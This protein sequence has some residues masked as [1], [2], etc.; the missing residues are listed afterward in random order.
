M[1]KESFDILADFFATAN[2][3]NALSDATMSA[4]SVIDYLSRI[5]II[6]MINEKVGKLNIWD[7]VDQDKTRVANM[8]F[9]RDG[10]MLASN[11]RMLLKIKREY[12]SELEGKGIRKNGTIENRTPLTS[13]DAAID[14][15]L[16]RH[17]DGAKVL[18]FDFEK[19]AKIST[20][21]KAIRKMSR[22][23]IRPIISLDGGSIKFYYD[24][25]LPAIQFM[26]DMD[27]KE[28]SIVPNTGVAALI[29][30][31]ENTC[32]IMPIY[33]DTRQMSN[34]FEM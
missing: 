9:H 11:R 17:T 33:G 1:K 2:A 31:D 10:Y 19:F 34:I 3:I 8:V 22:N 4:K 6:E 29:R 13:F 14:T 16:A 32:L 25:L 23:T 21:C 24:E 12:S 5:T 15:A 18:T 7:F 30:D 20:E 26:I 27:I 28:I